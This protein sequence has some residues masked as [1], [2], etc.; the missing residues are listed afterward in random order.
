MKKTLR[1]ITTE[2]QTYCHNGE[3]EKKLK[4]KILDAFYDIGDIKKV[5]SGNET[6]FVIDT[7]I[8]G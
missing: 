1:D 3:S 2:L 8:R 7:E 5:V 6:Y 4:I